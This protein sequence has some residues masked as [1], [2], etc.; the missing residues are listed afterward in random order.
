MQISVHYMKGI[1]VDMSCAENALGCMEV[2]SGVQWIE[3]YKVVI[4]RFG[5]IHSVSLFFY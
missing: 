1:K 2:Q 4:N 5:F 3:A